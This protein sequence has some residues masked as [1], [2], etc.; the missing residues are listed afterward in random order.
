MSFYTVDTAPKSDEFVGFSLGLSTFFSGRQANFGSVEL[1]C[2]DKAHITQT[3]VYPRVS[4]Q[5]MIGATLSG[6]V[7]IK[8]AS[9]WKGKLSSSA[10][11]EPEEVIIAFG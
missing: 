4:I 9:I 11:T 10:R 1:F 5:W 2:F 8:R 7:N 3:E 6:H